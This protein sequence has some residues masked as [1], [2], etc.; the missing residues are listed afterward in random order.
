MLLFFIFLFSWFVRA[1][2][3]MIGCKLK[4]FCTPWRESEVDKDNHLNSS[5]NPSKCYG[6]S[7]VYYL[8]GKVEVPVAMP[9]MIE[10][11]TVMYISLYTKTTDFRC[12]DF[13]F[14]IFLGACSI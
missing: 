5:E 10:V 9:K 11:N 12:V 3:T 8:S 14:I 7:V 4:V 2:S 1:D 13:Y 6:R